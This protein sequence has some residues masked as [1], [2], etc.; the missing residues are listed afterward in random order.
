VDAIVLPVLLSP[1]SETY[2]MNETDPRVSAVLNYLS[3]RDL[4]KSP[5]LGA[6]SA[7]L[8]LS[9]SRLRSIFKQQTGMSFSRYI[10]YLRLRRAHQLLENTLL[11]V[12]EAMAQAGFTDHS[13]FSR[14]YKKTFG[15]SPSQ[16]RSSCKHAT[17]VRA[18]IAPQNSQIGQAKEIA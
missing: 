5:A 10:K 14:D 4:T 6:L 7:S 8:N 13:H 16:T 18:L 17:A 15:E 12:K 2:N 9:P 1:V 3:Q 11:T